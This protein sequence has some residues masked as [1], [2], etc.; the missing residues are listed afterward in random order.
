MQICIIIEYIVRLTWNSDILCKK[1]R[2]LTNVPES[3]LGMST[4][5][6]VS[7]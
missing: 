4:K 6:A 2:L 5:N 7:L 3:Q 1:L